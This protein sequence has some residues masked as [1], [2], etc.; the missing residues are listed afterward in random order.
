VAAI[1]QDPLLE[2]NEDIQ[3]AHYYSVTEV[4]DDFWLYDYT[5]NDAHITGRTPSESFD[6]WLITRATPSD[7]Y[8]NEYVK[9]LVQ[10][11][12]WQQG[13]R[14]GR[15]W[16]LKTTQHLAFLDE[17]LAVYPKASMFQIHRHPRDFLGSLS[18]M[19]SR[20]WGLTTA[21]VDPHEV[22]RQY[23]AREKREIERYLESR[24]RLDLDDRIYDVQYEQIR[25]DPIPVFRE[26][27]RRAGHVMTPEAE[28]GM[29]EWERKNEQG[30]HGTYS[31]ALADFGLSD[32]II[33]DAFGEYI[34]RFVK[35]PLRATA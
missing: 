26:V 27:Y 13:G 16:L 22:G 12:Q 19:I 3:A 21:D 4:Q 10:Y 18:W 2:K 33:N 23:L 20:V 35:Q 11:L 28:R 1:G 17:V 6:K 25:K 14:Q 24:K 32:Q 29:I 15:R 5:F 8:N 31:Y 9:S 7:M 30:K 34:E